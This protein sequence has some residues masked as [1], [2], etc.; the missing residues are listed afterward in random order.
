MGGVIKFA[1]GVIYQGSL[2]NKKKHGKGALV[3]T[4]GFK[5]GV[6]KF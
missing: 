6:S 1:N 2:R 4:N 3:F 5:V